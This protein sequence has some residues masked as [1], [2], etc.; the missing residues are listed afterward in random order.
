MGYRSEVQAVIYGTKDNLDAYLTAYLYIID[1]P[2]MGSFQENL[3]RYI[4]KPHIEDT[5]I[6]IL[7]MTETNT[8]WYDGDPN[9][10]AW[11]RFMR[12][13]EDMDLKYEFIRVGEDDGDIERESSN[14]SEGYLYVHN[15]QIGNWFE[16]DN[17]IP[18]IG[19]T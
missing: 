12:D 19:A 6:H 18:L 1:S 9:I 13:S 14:H 8:K 15:P 5:E 7:H 2:I 3:K 10:K 17:P 16:Q 11:M 4:I